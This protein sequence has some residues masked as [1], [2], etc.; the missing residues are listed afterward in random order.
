M[1]LQHGLQLAAVLGQLLGSGLDVFKRGLD[2]F[3]DWKKNPKTIMGY[4]L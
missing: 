1:K 3:L 4:K 2:K